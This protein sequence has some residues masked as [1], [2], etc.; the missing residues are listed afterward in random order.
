M[1][2]QQTPGLAYESALTPST[3]ET[4]L[5]LGLS[6]AVW[7][8]IGAIA[9]LMAIVFWPNLRR[10]WLKTNPI[11]G[12]ANWGHAVFVPIAGLYYL[13]VNREELL[14][15]RPV[16]L[17]SRQLTMA[18]V[19]GMMQFMVW[20]V[21]AYMFVY[22]RDFFVHAS[23]VG[24]SFGAITFALGWRLHVM[25]SARQIT[26]VDRLWN[27]SAQWYGVYILIW[28]L[29]FYQ[30]GIYPGQNDMFKDYGMIITLFGVTLAAGGWPVMRVAWFPILFLVCAVPWSGLLYGRIAGPLQELAAKVAVVVLKLAQVAADDAGTTIQILKQDGTRRALN[31]AEACAGL[32]SLMTFVSVGAAYAFLSARPLW[33]K[34]LITVMAVPIAIFCNVV[35]VSGQGLLDYYVHQDLSQSF[36][37]QFVG[38]LMLIPAFFLI[39]LVGWLLDKLFVEVADRRRT[40][41]PAAVPVAMRA[42]VPLP[43]PAARSIALPRARS[44]RPSR[45]PTTGAAHIS[46]SSEKQP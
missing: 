6:K 16:Q 7:L 4:P 15:M 26:L 2:G 33:Q 42:A 37:H 36:A 23:V 18:A 27:S 29:L 32:R 30:Y 9:G 28:G 13:Y 40:T 20:G 19:W 43:A 31:V 11:S 34:L 8:R 25:T 21:I 12:E 14:G 46:R 38:M 39:L 17:R 45:S 44:S 10:L 22:V 41:G 24:L 5:Y 3:L 35:R 1:P